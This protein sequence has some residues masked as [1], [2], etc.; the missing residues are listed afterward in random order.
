M[1]AIRYDLY[2]PGHL[3]DLRGVW[4][5]P[6]VDQLA[7]LLDALGEISGSRRL[8]MGGPIVAGFT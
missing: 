2:G 4:A 3:I 8:S 1:Y 6:F 5:L 7:Q